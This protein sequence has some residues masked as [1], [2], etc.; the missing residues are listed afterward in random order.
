MCFTS[1]VVLF[2]LIESMLSLATSPP[3]CRAVPR[4]SLRPR[5][6][7]RTSLRSLFARRAWPLPE[8]LCF[9]LCAREE[10]SYQLTAYKYGSM[11]RA[12][13]NSSRSSFL[14]GKKSRGSSTARMPNDARNKNES[15]SSRRMSHRRAQA[16]KGK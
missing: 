4:V 8:Q 1:P 13:F 15:P 5:C 16:S 6:K 14:S 2:E 11:V 7:F 3:C 12:H 9:L 10:L